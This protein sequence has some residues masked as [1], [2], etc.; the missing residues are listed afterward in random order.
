MSPNSRPPLTSRIRASFEGKRSK[1][2]VTS[3]TN[4]NGFITQ[5]PEAFRNAIDESINSEAFQI[6]IAANLARIIK[7]SIK[8]ALD[9]LQPLVESVY[10]HE[11]LLRKTNRSVE[12]ILLRLDTQSLRAAG[13]ATPRSPGS[14]NSPATP[15]RR[16]EGDSSG[17][18]DIEQFK[19]S[20]EK[21]NKRTVATLAELA[22]AVDNNNK[23]VYDL[24]K[25]INEIQT[26]LGPTKKTLDSLKSY[27]EQSDTTTA[28]VQAQLD[29][30][31]ADVGLIIDAVGSDLGKN[32]NIINEQVAEHP[33][34]FAA[35]TTRLD[36]I[37][38]DLISLKGQADISEKVQGLSAEIEALK[39]LIETSANSNTENFKGLGTQLEL[40]FTEVESHAGTLSEIKDGSSNP[41]ILAAVQQSN[42]SH[43]SHAVLLSEIKERS[44][45]SGSETA[46]AS[47]PDR[48]SE[49]IAEIQALQADLAGLKANLEAGLSSHTEN[50]NGLGSMVDNVLS[51]VEGHRAADQGADI[52][53]AV[54]KSNDSHA[55]H[56]EALASVRTAGDD[57]PP[58]PAPVSYDTNFTALEEK[59]ASLHA[60]I[61]SHTGSLDEIKAVN[62]STS[63]EIVPVDDNSNSLSDLQN[64]IATIIN[65]LDDQNEALAEIK[66]DVSAEILTALHDV[67]QSQASHSTLLAELREADVSDEILTALHSSNESHASHTAAFAQLQ[68]AV[69]ASNDSHATH[70]TTL[71]EINHSA[72][73]DSYT[74]HA[75][76]LGEIKDATTASN[77]SHATHTATLAELKTVQPRDVPTTK[78][79]APS[80]LPEM[81]TH[82]ASILTKL[83]AQT[84]TLIEIKEAS[85]NPGVLTAVK[86]NHELLTSSHELLTSHTPL[87]ES[88]KAG[89]SHADIL[90]NIAELKS[91]IEDSKT[92]VDAHGAL[93]KDLHENTKSSHSELT[94]AIG[95]LALGGAAGVGAAVLVSKDDGDNSSEILSEVKAVRAMVEISSASIDATKHS[96]T[97]IASQIEINTT[98][99]TTSI[100]ALS[101]ELKAEIDATGTQLTESLSVLSGN[102]Q[103]ID[104]KS[105]NGSIDGCTAEVKGLSTSIE[106]LGGQVQATAGKVDGLAEGVHFS[107][108]G[109]GQ[110]KQHVVTTVPMA[111]GAWFKKAAPK[112]SREFEQ[113]EEEPIPEPAPE[114]VEVAEVP[115]SDPVVEEAVQEPVLG[116]VDE[117]PISDPVVEVA[118]AVPQISEETEAEEEVR[119]EPEI[120]PSTKPADSVPRDHDDD[121]PESTPVVEDAN[122]AEEESKNVVTED[123]KS[124]SNLPSDET[125]PNVKI[126]LEG[127]T[128][129]A[130][131]AKEQQEEKEPLTLEGAKP[132]EEADVGPIEES[133]VKPDPSEGEKLEATPQGSIGDEKPTLDAD[134]ILMPT[135]EVKPD[136][137][138]H[139]DDELEKPVTTSIEETK[140]ALTPRVEPE[141]TPAK[142]EVSDISPTKD[143]F[144]ETAPLASLADN[145]FDTASSLAS[146]T[147]NSASASTSAFASPSSASSPPPPGGKGKKGKKEKKEP[148]AKKGK[149]EKVPFSMDGE[150]PED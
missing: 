60:A 146:P 137:I 13:E 53:A 112:S 56:A 47:V 73:A 51:V 127:D 36:A 95:A 14:P 1:S 27:H 108:K 131:G 122:V 116:P 54:Q 64:G 101:D 11:V 50:L 69:Q 148:K 107:D 143:D 103:A 104:I 55:S 120:K 3:P 8:D 42:E 99:L 59:L 63:R 134:P 96:A 82:L 93:V 149:K 86:Q 20:L 62:T 48:K 28:V 118:A 138:P 106:A 74:V 4:T 79:A 88:L 44:L 139:D 22:S 40:V 135:E 72:L 67:G 15:R 100:N 61:E 71:D 129:S 76:T 124:E 39:A 7:P 85:T 24:I 35:H 66:D 68:T 25:G 110:L 94:T 142:E 6:S 19:Q 111:E 119:A 23:K 140:P 49:S 9:T 141:L 123:P 117:G 5:D 150:E 45:K 121:A 147:E 145:P 136:L 58:A 43:A 80:S 78:V 32:V 125:V 75:A 30:L 31:K 98:T 41:E 90:T 115:A 84:I 91:V 16:G 130:T 21:N 109:V 89:I 26:T 10:S 144:E 87:L 133:E 46:A 70:S 34:L 12:N 83:D 17:P 97:S 81:E 114:E 92:G 29:Q 18:Q 38:G 37:S 105:L 65:K 57:A 128:V 2:E 52:L 77:E 33:N 102:V 126:D 113:N 132:T